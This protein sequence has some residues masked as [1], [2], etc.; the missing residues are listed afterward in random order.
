MTV[1]IYAPASIGNLSVGFDLLGAAISPIDGEILGDRVTVSAVPEGIFLHS[2]GRWA[3]KLPQNPHDNIVYQCAEFFLNHLGEN[4]GLALTLEKN[5]PTGSG[6]GSSASS[7]V[8]ALTALNEFFT[9]PFSSFE[10]IK[11]MGIFEGRISGSVHYDNVAPSYLGGMQLMLDSATNVS[12]AIPHF[13][14]WFWIVAYPGISLSTAAMRRLVPDKFERATTIDFGRNL[15]TFVHASYK[16]DAKLAVGVLKDVLAE[17]YRAPE[18]PNFVAAK[19][20]LAELGV[21][22]TG[23]SGS[24]PTLFCVTDDINVAQAAKAYLAEF[25]IDSEQGFT[26]ICQ[27][28]PQGARHRN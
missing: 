8:A 15:A 25:Y 2:T 12:G 23:I 4:T 19:A 11:L 10:L 13:Q 26:Y 9:K 7:I 20:A 6:L 16:Q 27:I 22:A 28:D 24:G 14:H 1:T 3:H 5:L 21:L 17:P 18:I